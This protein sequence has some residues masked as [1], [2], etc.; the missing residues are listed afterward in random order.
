MVGRDFRSLFTLGEQGCKAKFD[1]LQ[2]ASEEMLLSMRNNDTDGTALDVQTKCTKLFG[3]GNDDHS[4]I[5]PLPSDWVGP[6]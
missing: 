3:E 5:V 2:S 1:C 4:A 6:G